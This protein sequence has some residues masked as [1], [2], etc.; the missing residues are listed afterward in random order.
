M[1]LNLIKN[2]FL[3]VLFYLIYKML[4]NKL[5]FTYHLIIIYFNRVQPISITTIH[6]IPKQ[7]NNKRKFD[8]ITI[9]DNDDS[10]ESKHAKLSQDCKISKTNLNSK[11]SNEQHVES[12]P[13]TTENVEE[14]EANNEL[15]QTNLNSETSDQQF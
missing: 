13:Q 6:L 4:L 10:S 7:E 9:N 15:D 3:L 1:F 11:T 14:F 8:I 2:S 12:N 5:N